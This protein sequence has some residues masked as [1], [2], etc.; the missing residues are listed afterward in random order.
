LADID[1]SAILG[2][3]DYRKE[4]GRA[5][6]TIN[7]DLAVLRKTLRVAQELGKLDV[8]PRIRMLRPA[9]PRAGFF[10]EAQFERVAKALPRDLALVARV[11]YVLGWRLSSEVL[12]L[13]RRQVDLSEGTL[14]LEPDMGK[15]RETRVAYLTPELKAGIAKQLARVKD[16]E[17]RT[18]AIVSWL[19]PY[20]GAGTLA[21]VSGHFANAG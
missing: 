13:T 10:E 12:T 18:G 20:L 17:R 8:V 2:H 14:R 21:S 3:V 7:A 11:G 4:Q 15:N 9:P 16:L 6:A 5:N 1:P 19:F